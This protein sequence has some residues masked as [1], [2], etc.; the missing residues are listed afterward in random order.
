MI[1]ILWENPIYDAIEDF[2]TYMNDGMCDLTG[3]GYNCT[4]ATAVARQ[5][6]AGRRAPVRQRV[7]RG[8]QAP[9]PMR[10]APM[11]APAP[12]R[13][14]PPGTGAFVRNMRG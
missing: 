8:P 7:T 12:M 2:F 13:T 4:P 3:Y 6:M 11:R 10:S 9:G 5:A 1:E 14:A